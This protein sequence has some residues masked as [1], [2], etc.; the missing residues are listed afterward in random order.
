QTTALPWLV[1]A[2]TLH[3]LTFAL[4]HLACLGLIEAGVPP[5][6]RAT[7]LTL[8]GTVA[9]GL[10]GA[11]LALAAGSLY[12]ALGAGAFWVM[13]ALCLAALPLALGLR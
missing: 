2:Q 3:G 6:L 7:A 9:L 10:A 11:A 1:G 4:L 12:G 13:A 5:A 8:Y